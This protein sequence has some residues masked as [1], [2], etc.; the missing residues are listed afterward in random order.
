[1]FQS[2]LN[3]VCMWLDSSSKQ[4]NSFHDTISTTSQSNINLIAKT[5]QIDRRVEETPRG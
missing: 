1:M 2:T 3:P 5:S 4:L